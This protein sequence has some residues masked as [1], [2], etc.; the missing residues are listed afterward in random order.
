MNESNDKVEEF[1]QDEA[2]DQWIIMQDEKIENFQFV[3]AAIFK[4]KSTM[5]SLINKHKFLN[6]D[7]FNRYENDAKQEAI[8]LFAEQFDAE[9]VKRLI[10][11]FQESSEKVLSELKLLNEMQHEKTINFANTMLHSSITNFRERMREVLLTVST[12]SE[13]NE[14]QDTIVNEITTSFEES[15]NYKEKGFLEIYMLKHHKGVSEAS[16]AF[17]ADFHKILDNITS[18]FKQ[19]VKECKSSY[20]EVN[21]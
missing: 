1:V 8:K 16:K 10:S 17:L 14:K 15:L 12:F 6:N 20:K 5:E 9:E 18:S 19:L 11:K 2:M 4:Y 3:E 13:L 21:K 7:L